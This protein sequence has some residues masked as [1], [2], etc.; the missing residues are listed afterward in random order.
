MH[1]EHY[2]YFA[3]DN[4]QRYSFYSSGPKGIVKKTVIYS[5]MQDNPVVYNLAFGDENPITGEI[6][7]KVVTNNQDRDISSIYGSQYHTRFY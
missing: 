1:L 6:D 3:S 7:D 5:K 4:F 2:Q